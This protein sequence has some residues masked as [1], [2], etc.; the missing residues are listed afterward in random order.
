MITQYRKAKSSGRT[1]GGGIAIVYI[2]GLMVVQELKIRRGWS[3]ILCAVGRIPGK[4]RRINLIGI[5][6]PPKMKAEKRREALG[7]LKDAIALAKN[8]YK[9]QYVIISGDTNKMSLKRWH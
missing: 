9:D 8:D 2:T 7:C 1:A 4:A 5:Y 6:L 3:E